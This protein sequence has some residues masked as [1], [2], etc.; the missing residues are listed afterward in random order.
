[1]ARRISIREDL[2]MIIM[3]ETL[4][5]DALKDTYL[6]LHCILTSRQNMEESLLWGLIHLNFRL[7]E[8]ED[9]RG[10]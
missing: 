7:A 5:V 8:E 4:Y 10:R 2:R 9:A 1:M 6:T 3:E